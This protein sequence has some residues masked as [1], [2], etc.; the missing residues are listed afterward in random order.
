[1]FSLRISL[2]KILIL[3]FTKNVF[4]QDLHHGTS[5]SNRISNKIL[6]TVKIN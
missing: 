6:K 4:C 1:M 5:I 3:I 2:N